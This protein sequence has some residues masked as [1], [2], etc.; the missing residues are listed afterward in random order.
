M[1]SVAMA[2]VHF[3]IVGCAADADV[4]IAAVERRT[5]A[6]ILVNIRRIHSCHCRDGVQSTRQRRSRFILRLFVMPNVIYV[7]RC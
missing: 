4:A 2:S 5:T 6:F 1:A 7:D 3:A